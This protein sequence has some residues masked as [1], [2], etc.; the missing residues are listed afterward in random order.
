MVFP[1]SFVPGYPD[2][3]WRRLPMSDGDWMSKGN[4]TIVAPGGQVVA[5]PLVGETGIVTAELDRERITA[6]RR[7]FDPV[8]H[9]ARP[10]VLRLVRGDT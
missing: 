6:G 8:G 5:G 7:M 4:S 2:W 10:D 3:V 9:Y 1:E